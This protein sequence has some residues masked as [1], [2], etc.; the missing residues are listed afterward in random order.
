MS[1]EIIIFNN[2]EYQLFIGKNAKHN[3]ELIDMSDPDDVWF[4]IENYPST[5]VIL[6]N[7]DKLE[8]KKIPHQILYLCC[9]KCKN[10]ISKYRT[11]NNLSV[12]FT[13]IKN[14]KK[15]IEIGSVYA[16]NIK[17]INV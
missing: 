14:V 9:V 11:I 4:H 8:I 5:H 13:Q 1:N 15:G 6:K 2:I 7:P 12:C 3:W 16:E 10:R 17:S